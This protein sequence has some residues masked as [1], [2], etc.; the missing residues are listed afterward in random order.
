MNKTYTPEELILFAYNETGD[1]KSRKIIEALGNDEAL[2]EEYNSIISVQTALN[3][4]QRVPSEQTINYILN[5]SRALNVFKLKPA[6]NTCFVV[7]N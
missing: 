2:R 7:V 3:S 5:Y 6:V 1:K 4:M